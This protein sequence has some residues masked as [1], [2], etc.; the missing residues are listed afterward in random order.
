[1]K[2][3]QEKCIDCW[4][5]QTKVFRGQGECEQPLPSQS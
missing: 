1:M 4:S 5:F 3:V 2:M